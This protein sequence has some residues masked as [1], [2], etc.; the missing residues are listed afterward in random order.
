MK[1]LIKILPIMLMTAGQ[2]SA[3]TT[4]GLRECMQY[5]VEN[6][7][8][9]AV[10]DERLSQQSIER[11]DAW[12]NAF[13]PSVTASSSVSYS[14]GRIPDPETNM[15]STLKTIQD[16]YQLYGEITLFDGFSAINRI[17]ISKIAL[18]S[19]KESRQAKQ[20]DI[21]LNTIQQYCSYT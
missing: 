18:L 14:S 6:S 15:Y 3:Q 8:K 17:K 1:T 5:A 7:T 10:E 12:L 16:S 20:D 4:M 21:C 9:I 11:R 2:T 13:T 19:G